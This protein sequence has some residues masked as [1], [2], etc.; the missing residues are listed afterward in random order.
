VE[1]NKQNYITYLTNLTPNNPFDF[2][3]HNVHSDT[4]PTVSDTAGWIFS[5]VAGFDVL[6]K[7]MK[8]A[9]KILLMTYSNKF[10]KKLLQ[11]ECSCSS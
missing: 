7:Q 5:I 4:R 10:A 1:R 2:L 6:P 9:N 3:E 11:S 8:R